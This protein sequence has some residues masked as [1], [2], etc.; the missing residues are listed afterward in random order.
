VSQAEPSSQPKAR[1]AYPDGL[2]RPRRYWAILALMSSLIATVL[3][4]SMVNVALPTITRE[5]NIDP[6]E[7]VWVV[8]VYNLIVVVSL[9]PLSAMAERIGFKRMFRLGLT[10]FVGASVISAMATSLETLIAGRM[11]QG[12]AS[13]MLMCM[14][15]GL[16][17]N[18]YPLNK[19]GMGISLNATMVGVFSVLGPTIGALVLHIASWEWIFLIGVP[20]SLAGV[21]GARFLPDVPRNTSRFDW[22]ACLLSIPVLG[23]SIIGLDSLVTHPLRALI[24]VALAALAAWLLVRR[25]RNQVAPLFPLDLLRIRSITYAVGAS[26]FSFA[27][28]MSGFVALPFYF[29]KVLNFSYTDVGLLLGMWSIGVAAMAPVAGMLSGRYPIS[30]LCAIGAGSMALGMLWLLLLPQGTAFF[31]L[32]AAMLLAGIGFGFF[33]TPNN[34]ALLSAAPRRRSGAAG[35]LQATSRVF[36][37]GC[38]TA[39]VALVFTLGQTHGPTLGVVMSIIC[40]VCALVV[41]ILRYRDKTPDRPAS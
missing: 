7:V 27:A 33:Q 30:I 32:M 6:A 36:G 16:V 12:F 37:Q 14:F 34:R 5:L 19:L 26:A 13:A 22:I 20:I 39:L 10:L 18:I 40:G 24:C 21:F 1:S 4:A 2:E 23:L 17:R 28:Q 35:G 3:D 9:L 31:W 41:N 29:Q 38:G 11:A 25:S 8:T 15:G